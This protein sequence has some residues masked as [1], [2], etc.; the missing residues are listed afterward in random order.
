MMLKIAVSRCLLGEAVRFDGNSKPCA[1]VREL[2]AARAE[3]VGVCPEVEVGMPVPRE[4]VDLFGDPS[5]TR[6]IGARTGEDWTRRLDA[7]ARERINDLLDQG[8]AGAVLKARSPSCG[9]GDAPVH[10]AGSGDPVAGDGLFALALRRAAP[11][12]PI[13]RDEDLGEEAGVEE[14]LARARAYACGRAR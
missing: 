5:G 8:I 4:P 2:L 9:V 10:P 13:A 3:L 12:L 6:M 7:W 1:A 14:F 11:G